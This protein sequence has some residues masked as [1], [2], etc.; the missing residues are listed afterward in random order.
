[1][2]GIWITR[3]DLTAADLRVA[4]GNARALVRAV[5]ISTQRFSFMKRPECKF[6]SRFRL[7]QRAATSS[8]LPTQSLLISLKRDVMRIFRNKRIGHSKRRSL[9]DIAGKNGGLGAL[10]QSQTAQGRRRPK[11]DENSLRSWVCRAQVSDGNTVL[12][13]QTDLA[14]WQRH[15]VPGQF[16]AGFLGCP[17]GKEPGR[18]LRRGKVQKAPRFVFGKTRLC[19]PCNINAPVN[20]FQINPNR[21]GSR[22]HKNRQPRAMLQ[23]E[24]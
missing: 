18:L 8:A 20:K 2:A 15:A 10:W 7:T 19:Q 5:R 24:M 4:A 22:D 21:P 17:K 9:T 23:V 16:H 3:R 11:I 1:M 14:W 13:I 6:W 12:D